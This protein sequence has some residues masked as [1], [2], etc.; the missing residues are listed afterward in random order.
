MGYEFEIYKVSDWRYCEHCLISSLEDLKR[1][2]EA[3]NEC[4][5]VIDLTERKI[6]IYDDYLE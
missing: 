4:R 1:L 2:Q 6:I 3:N 5:L